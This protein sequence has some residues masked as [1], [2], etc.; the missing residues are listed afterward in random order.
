MACTQI[1][2]Q[3]GAQ[4]KNFSAVSQMDFNQSLVSSEAQANIYLNSS[5][6]SEMY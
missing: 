2:V 1:L 6:R 3:V 4:H 5:K